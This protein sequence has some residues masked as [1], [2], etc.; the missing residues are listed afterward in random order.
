MIIVKLKLITKLKSKNFNRHK[1]VAEGDKMKYLFLLLLIGCGGGGD[2]SISNGCFNGYKT[3]DTSAGFNGSLYITD[4][5]IEITTHTN[6]ACKDSNHC[7]RVELSKKVNRPIEIEFSFIVDKFVDISNESDCG[8]FNGGRLKGCYVIISQFWNKQA[9]PRAYIVLQ[10]KRTV[11][12]GLEPNILTLYFQNKDDNAKVSTL[13]QTEIEVGE[14]NEIKLTDSGMVSLTVNDEFSG[15]IT[16]DTHGNSQQ[17]FK[18][19]AYWQPEVN[20]EMVIRF[21][22]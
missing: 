5:E 2:G 21:L 6:A 14:W 7:R 10:R 15:F 11:D 9:G 18:F 12:G 17:Y 1:A 22:L 8:T 4:C 13:W 3:Q 20:S 16:A 19:G